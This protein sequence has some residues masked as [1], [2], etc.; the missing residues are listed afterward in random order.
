MSSSIIPQKR[1]LNDSDDVDSPSPK[2]LK[3]NTGSSIITKPIEEIIEFYQMFLKFHP[4]EKD[5]FID[6][7]KLK[8]R[9]SR[10]NGLHNDLSQAMINTDFTTVRNMR[11]SAPR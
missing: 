5:K 11:E 10:E 7:T 3:A 6:L 4:L 8:E 1:E 2:R 9:L